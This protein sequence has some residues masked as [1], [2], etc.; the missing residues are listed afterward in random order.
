MRKLDE[1]ANGTTEEIH[2]GRQMSPY[3]LV[4][5]EPSHLFLTCSFYAT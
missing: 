1:L 2:L 5:G 3:N 4:C